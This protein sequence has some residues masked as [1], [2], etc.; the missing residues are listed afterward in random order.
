MTSCISFCML[1][2]KHTCE[3][4]LDGATPLSCAKHWAQ[5]SG[6]LLAVPSQSNRL[7]DTSWNHMSW[8]QAFPDEDRHVARENSIW[9]T[10]LRLRIILP[11]FQHQQILMRSTKTT[12]FQYQ[13]Q[14]FNK[15]NMEL[16]I[17][18]YICIYRAI[19]SR[20]S[21]GSPYR[22]PSKLT[23]IACRAW[24]TTEMACL[25]SRRGWNVVTRP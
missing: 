6:C 1:C 21:Q 3:L 2:R 18:I 8:N 10:K 12:S 22:I 16:R 7:S 23:H 24:A 11:S 13:Y 4:D 19:C 14:R 20:R 9:Q 25:S 17:Y 5:F 15:E